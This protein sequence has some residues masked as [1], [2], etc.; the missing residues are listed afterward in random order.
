MANLSGIKDLP[1]KKHDPWAIGKKTFLG[2][3]SINPS[4]GMGCARMATY[5]DRFMTYKLHGTCPDDSELAH[6]LMAGG[7]DHCREEDA[8]QE[9]PL[10]TQNHSRSKALS[11]TKP[12]DHKIQWNQYKCKNYSCLISPETVGK[13]VY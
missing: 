4:I 7:C 2:V 10:T 6:K 3:E 11:G 9:H 8:F 13:R 5:L 1:L 12:S